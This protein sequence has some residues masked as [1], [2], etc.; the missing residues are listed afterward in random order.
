LFSCDGRN[1]FQK[2]VDGLA[3][4]QILDQ[5]LNRT[6]VPVKTVVPPPNTSGEELITDGSGLSAIYKGSE[7][8]VDLQA[9]GGL[10]GC[11]A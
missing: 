9:Y 8:R 10:L 3:A 11:A 2:I 4:F 6:R 7:S 5:R 1:P